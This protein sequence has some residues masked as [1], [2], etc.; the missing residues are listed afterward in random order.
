MGALGNARDTTNKLRIFAVVW[1]GQF[2]SIIGS[3]L[4]S[5]A[6]GLWVYERTA[7]VTPFALIALSGALP[8]VLLLPFA[9]AIVD[10]WDRRAAMITGDTGAALSAIVVALLLFSGRLEV[11][12]VYVAVAAGAVFSSLQLPAYL[13]STT[14][15]LP[16]KHYARAG[17]LAQL[18]Q[19]V[20]DVAAPL[21]AGLLIGHIGVGGVVL[22]D[23]TTFLF[24]V[25]TALS[26]RFPTLG[27]SDEE[28][29]EQREQRQHGS[30]FRETLFGWR[31]IGARPGLLGL[32][33]FFAAFYF[34][35]GLVG[36]LITPMILAFAPVETLGLIL[37]FAGGGILAGALLMSLWGGPAPERRVKA[38]LGFQLLGG[39]CF[40]LIGLQPSAAL[41]A[42]AAFGAHVTIPVVFSLNHALWQS[43]VASELQGRVFATRQMIAKLATPAAYLIAGPLADKVFEPL[44]Q[45]QGLLAASV[46]QVLGVGKGRGIGLLFVLMGLL[47]ILITL[48]WSAYPAVR[49]IER[50]LPD[51][52]NEEPITLLGTGD[53]A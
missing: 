8:G 48:L 41:I 47:S 10:R 28:E 33:L 3:G 32:L 16:K 27:T 26:V 38:I 14:L 44:L 11:W 49:N 42:L 52:L 19:G 45:P 17:G 25:A 24:A 34:L 37:S 46:G 6:L 15:M 43:K 53:R 13:A 1:I 12:H 29:R 2:V 50:E 31:Y 5:F 20:S 35:W 39:I 51:A 40:L 7:S 9:G 22:I 30:L 4:T 36:P 18:S 21:L 23:A